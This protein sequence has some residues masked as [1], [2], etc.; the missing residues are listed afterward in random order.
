MRV[1]E[2]T[3]GLADNDTHCLVR[4]TAFDVLIDKI[5]R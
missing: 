2:S 3:E 4:V 1:P 5:A